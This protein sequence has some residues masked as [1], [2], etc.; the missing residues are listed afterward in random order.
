MFRDG[1]AEETARVIQALSKS[2]IDTELY[3]QVAGL[4]NNMRVR[5]YEFHN[6]LLNRTIICDGNI[7][8]YLK[9]IQDASKSL[10]AYMATRSP[11]TH[12]LEEIKKY[13]QQVITTVRKTRRE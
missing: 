9:M 4:L 1:F 11:E 12:S 6:E 7:Q 10:T 8:L 13:H 3:M 2:D 5:I